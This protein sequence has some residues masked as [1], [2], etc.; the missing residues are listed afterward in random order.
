MMKK[1]NVFFA[2]LLLVFFS[3]CMDLPDDL[4]A[5]EWDTELNLPLINKSY[6]LDEIIKPQA[7]IIVDTSGTDIYLLQSDKYYLN[8][9]LS[10]F[11]Y[12]S[13]QFRSTLPTLTSDNDSAVAYI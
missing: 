4:I 9:N 3:G 5:P 12:R 1:I 8:S 10:E 13:D 7:H 6:T 2:I 11:V